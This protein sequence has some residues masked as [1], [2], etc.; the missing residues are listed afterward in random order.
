MLRGT[1]RLQPPAWVPHYWMITPSFSL[2]RLLVLLPA[3]ALATACKPSA[4]PTATPAVRSDRIPLQAVTVEIHD[5]ALGYLPGETTP[6]TGDAITPFGDTP[7]LVKIREPWSAGKK[8]GEVI[9]Y[10]KNGE[11]K[12]VRRYDHGLPKHAAAFHK[13]GQMKFELALNAQDNGEGPYRRWYPDG[14]LECEAGFDSEER[15]DGSS[16][17]YSKNGEL[18]SHYIFEHGALRQI[19]FENEEGKAFRKAHNVEL[20]PESAPAPKPPATNPPPAPN[21]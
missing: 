12:S 3:V 10:F 2:A 11:P 17:E 15:W 21:P 7:W 13:N 19:V 14:K 8:H 1:R 4:S 6:F 16:K 9:E 5:D 18:R 20:E